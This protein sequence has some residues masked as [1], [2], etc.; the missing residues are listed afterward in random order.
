M[1][2]R[3]TWDR[4]LTAREGVDKKSL[5]AARW[6]R[7]W[8]GRI[9]MRHEG[10]AGLAGIL[11]QVGRSESTVSLESVQVCRQLRRRVCCGLGSRDENSESLLINLLQAG[12]MPPSVVRFLLGPVAG[13]ASVA[14]ALIADS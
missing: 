12:I 8:S 6:H 7:H 1:G 11:A 2:L 5:S 10:D 4:S 14:G 13:L 9:P 3:E